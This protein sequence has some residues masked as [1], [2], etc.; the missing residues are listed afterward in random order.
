[1]NARQWAAALLL[2][3]AFAAPGSAQETGVARLGPS[4]IPQAHRPGA[5]PG[6]GLFSNVPSGFSTG[7]RAIGDADGSRSVNTRMVGTVDVDTNTRLGV[8]LFRV[9]RYSSREPGFQRTSTIT[10]MG[11]RTQNIA[12]VGMSLKF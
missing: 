11:G 9:N 10:N 8:G 5:N 4:I 7:T 6:D 2:S 3:C 1:M 12:A